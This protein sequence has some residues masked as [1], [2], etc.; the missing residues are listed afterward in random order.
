VL[1][2]STIAPVVYEAWSM[3]GRASWHVSV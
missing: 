1:N 3:F 2:V